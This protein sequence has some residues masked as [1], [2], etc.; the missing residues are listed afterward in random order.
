MADESSEGPAVPLGT[1]AGLDASEMASA[2]APSWFLL[3]TVPVCGPAA[4]SR[5]IHMM[6]MRFPASGIAAAVVRGGAALA[7]TLVAAGCAG[8]AGG[9][10]PADA[11]SLAS[12]EPAAEP[13]PSSAP[14]IHPRW[15]SCAVEPSMRPQDEGTDA[16]A[17]PRFAGTFRPVA[18]VRC[19]EGEQRRP[20]GGTD[21]IAVEDRADDVAALLDGLRLPDAP[22][23]DDMACDLGGYLPPRLVLLDDQGRWVRPSIPRDACAKPLAETTA[24]MDAL[25][26]TR[27][28]TRVLGEAESAGAAA[29]G[30]DQVSTDMVWFTGVH[31]PGRPG[32][33]AP[34]ADDAASVRL[35]RYEVTAKGRD[36][37]KPQGDF[38][39]GGMLK[40]P[41]SPGTR[42]NCESARLVTFASS[43]T[44]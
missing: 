16:V 3:L 39:S 30:C 32:E 21:A 2:A 9:T 33:L 38:V 28:T 4:R 20:D 11:Q 41:A 5:L 19:S 44:R 29:S 42:R 27:V 37:E 7:V 6:T 1:V 13:R 22:P 12:A 36:S 25:H 17:L 40:I 26:W 43:L 18:A 31:P 14:R 34:M 35:C 15:R 8:Q 24:A 10:A 23:S